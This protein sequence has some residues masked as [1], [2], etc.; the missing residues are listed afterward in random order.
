[1]T[2]GSSRQGPRT[3]ASLWAGLESSGLG[4]PQSSQLHLGHPPVGLPLLRLWA[5]NSSI[6]VSPVVSANCSPYT[7]KGIGEAGP[8]ACGCG[9]THRLPRVPVSLHLP[10]CFP[11]C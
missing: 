11:C 8:I 5:P 3:I 6:P 4:D 1:M 9:C 10:S 2:A 7:Q